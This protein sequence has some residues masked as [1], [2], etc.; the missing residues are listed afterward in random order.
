MAQDLIA[1]YVWIVDTLTRYKKLTRR[2]INDLWIRS[3]FSG[4][5]PLP[6][7][8][9]FHYR[10]AIEKNFHIDI[11]CNS[12]GEYYIDQDESDNSRA[13]KNL[14]LDSFAVNSAL[15]EFSDFDGKIQVENIPSAREFLSPVMEAAKFSRKIVFS[16]EGYNRS[17]AEEDILFHPYS[18][19]LYKQ[20]WYMV[21]LKEKENAIRTYALDRIRNLNI[22]HDQFPAPAENIAESV[23]GNII[24]V[25]SSKADARVVR[26]KADRTQAKYLRDLP[27]HHSQ[28]EEIHDSYSIF[29]YRLKLNY[30]LTHE[31]LGFGAAVEVI[32]PKE[33]KAM[34]ISELKKN[35]AIYGQ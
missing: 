35:L 12:C 33:L 29:T 10:R 17:R 34:I 24:G 19:K 26:I 8:T 27:L 31:I 28:Q 16:Y 23:F 14:L 4:G 32:E 13:F 7:R 6:E 22:L 18:L 2:Q 11:A 9:F 21:G 25:T 20:R 15:R 3:S 30:E 5:N 1:R